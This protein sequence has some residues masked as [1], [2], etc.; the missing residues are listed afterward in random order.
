MPMMPLKPLLVLSTALT[1]TPNVAAQFTQQQ[2]DGY[3]QAVVRVDASKCAGVPGG[4]LVGSGFFW[5]QSNWVVT[6]LHVV[7]NCTSVSGYSDT[8]LDHSPA[9]VSKILLADDLALLTL[10]QPI[11]STVVLSTAKDAPQDTQ[12]LLVVGFPSDSN[13]STGKTVKRQFS[14]S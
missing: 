1:L 11:T 13:G 6:A 14:G 9:Q 8:A 10:S 5:K 4:S 12:D 7:N 2:I 3:R